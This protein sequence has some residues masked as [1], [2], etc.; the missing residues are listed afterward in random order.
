V[1]WPLGAGLLVVVDRLV[2]LGVKEVFCRLPT[3]RSTLAMAAAIWHNWATG[4][5]VN[6]SLIAY[7]N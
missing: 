5:P 7:D 4:E 1:K 3:F 2:V 6:R